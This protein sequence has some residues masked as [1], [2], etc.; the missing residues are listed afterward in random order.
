[1]K[2]IDIVGNI[3]NG[4]QVLS[5]VE[6]LKPTYWLCRCVCGKIFSTTKQRL[7]LS[8]TKSCGCLKEKLRKEKN[9]N[10]RRV[11]QW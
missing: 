8:N 1:M 7:V 11:C 3:Y 2:R 5:R 10:S 4:I 9:Y 6:G